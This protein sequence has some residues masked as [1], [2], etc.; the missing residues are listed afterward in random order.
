MSEAHLLKSWSMVQTLLLFALGLDR[1]GNQARAGKILV[2]AR[3]LALDIGMNH[4]DYSILNGRG[5]SICE[6]SLRRTWWELYVV[7]ILFAGL[8]GKT[9]GDVRGMTN[10]TVPLPC[11]EHEFATGV[12]SPS[13]NIHQSLADCEVS[14]TFA[15]YR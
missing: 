15:H 4:S 6:E 10:A 14:R 9:S 2:K 8:H 7:T 3:E 5:S 13:P 12:S 1:G 11:E